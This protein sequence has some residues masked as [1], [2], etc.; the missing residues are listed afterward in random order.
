V[1]VA[2]V[3]QLVPGSVRTLAPGKILVAARGLPDPNFSETV[4]LLCDYNEKGAMGLVINRRSELK[5]THAFPNLKL[6][7]DYAPTFFAGGPVEPGG[8]LA[9]WRTSDARTDARQC[10]PDVQLVST[11]PQLESLISIGTGMDHLRV[12]AGYSGWGPGQL[13]RETVTGSWHVFSIDASVVFDPD[14]STL[15]ER[16]IKR[17]QER[18][19]RAPVIVNRQSSIVNYPSRSTSTGSIRAARQAGRKAASVPTQ[20]MSAMA[21]TSVATSRASSP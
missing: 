21:P 7:R 17:A 9:L 13:D 18:F 1:A 11:R 15:W 12:F 5:V 14:P 3:R 20:A 10:L 2:V 16:Q 8:V 6:A 19:A 4:V